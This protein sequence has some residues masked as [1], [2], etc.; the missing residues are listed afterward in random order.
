MCCL[1]L[2][3]SSNNV[4][5]QDYI[6]KWKKDLALIMA[7]GLLVLSLCHCELNEHVV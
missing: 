5:E 1:C 6:A 3:S 2:N 4:T 7:V